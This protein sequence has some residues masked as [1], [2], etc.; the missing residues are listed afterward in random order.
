MMAPLYA[1]GLFGSSASLLLAV[2]IGIA[3][4]FFLERGGLGSSTKLA[5]QFY[6]T[7]MS[8]F[9]VM[10]T[11]IVTAML[12]L[13]WLSWLGFLDLSAVY[14]NPT[15]VLPQL[16]GGFVFGIGFISA[17][18]CPG[19]ACVALA[20]GKM[21]GLVVLV[22]IFVGI[23]L[24]G[25][26]FDYFY[27]FMVSTSMGQ[28]TLPQ[29]FHLSHGLVVLFVVLV[30][31]AGFFGAGVVERRFSPSNGERCS[32]TPALRVE[33]TLGI[34]ALLLGVMA[35]VS[36]NPIRN[37][38][39]DAGLAYPDSIQG[40]QIAYLEP[41]QLAESLMTRRRDMTVWD[42]RSETDFETYHIP[43]AQHVALSNVTSH[44]IP[45]DKTTI[46]Y[47][48]DGQH[49]AQAWSAITE[50]G[51]E[52]VFVLQGGLASWFDEIL[53]PDLTVARGRDK[54]AIEKTKRR[55]RYF[56]GTPKENDIGK[57]GRSRRYLREG[58]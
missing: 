49:A 31:V 26:T 32:K 52:N 7:D 45:N 40:R 27:D 5:A 35:A 57:S 20:T 17:G 25:E 39:I 43:S 58:C 21:D 3:F 53:F 50:Q 29:F 28:V 33:K 6:L 13:Y 42:L 48:D 8:V 36:G 55:S 18:L 12:G 15:Y 46:L 16:T 23:F 51:V 1:N 11:A 24:F 22:G 2:F 4:G 14:V 54:T 9:K 30:A 19:T 37:E 41:V 44:K 10:F 34:I 38:Q 47:A 56:G